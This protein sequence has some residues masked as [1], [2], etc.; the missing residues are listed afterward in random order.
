MKNLEEFQAEVSRNIDKNSRDIANMGKNLGG[1]NNRIGEI[2]ETILAARA[3]EKFK[4]YNYD[5]ERAFQR[6][7]IY[8]GKERLTDAD[9][10]LANGKFA[11]AIEV[12]NT[13]NRIADVDDHVER[14][15]DI[16]KYPPAETKGKIVLGAMAC[17][18]VNAKVRDYAFSKGLFV[19]ELTGDTAHLAPTP[20]DFTP[21]EWIPMANAT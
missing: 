5:F 6:V 18:V 3:W 12:K 2:M 1:L 8:N 14:M 21:Q 17:G 19:L 11:M 16:V 9:I 13:L 4:D 15:E 10:I 7:G 20:A